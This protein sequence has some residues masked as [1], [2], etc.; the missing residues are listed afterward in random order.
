MSNNEEVIFPLANEKLERSEAEKNELR[1]KLE[2][3]EAEMNKLQ[4]ENNQKKR[5][6]IVSYI[7]Y[8]KDTCLVTFE[9]L[10]I[11]LLQFNLDSLVID[12]K[13]KVVNRYE[14]RKREQVS[15]APATTPSSVWGDN[16]MSTFRFQRMFRAV[17]RQIKKITF[18]CVTVCCINLS[19]LIKL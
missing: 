6:L 15:T 14:N 13:N 16:N 4:A 3:M 11:F 5:G 19:N 17:D 1:E 10:E 8:E 12:E 9:A 7:L 2:R 18:T